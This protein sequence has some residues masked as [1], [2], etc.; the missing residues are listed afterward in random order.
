MYFGVDYY[1]EHWVFPYGGT[2]KNPRRLGARRR[3]DGQSRH[4]RRPHRRIHPGASANPRRANTISPGC[5]ASWTSWRS[6]TSR[7]SS[8]RPP[9]RRP[10]GWPRNIPEIL[11]LDERGLRQTRRHP[12][13]GLLE[14]RRLLGIFQTHRQRHGRGAGRPSA[15]DRLAD[16]QQ[17][18]RASHRIFLQRGTRDGMASLAAGQIQ[19]HRAA[20]RHAGPALLGPDRDLLG[21]GAHADVRA[22]ACTIRRWCWIGAASAATPWCSS[23]RCRRTFCTNVARPSRHRQHARLPPQVRSFRHGRSR[24]FRFHRK[25]RRHQI[26]ILRTG[27]RH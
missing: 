24:G 9:P 19:N 2:A 22:H 5:A 16:R 21:P 4:Q 6:T 26:Q 7:S 10:S 15:I 27:L 12:P 17:H 3:I 25:Q 8:A 11:P 20:Q 23:S 13:R 18:R 14:Q 1:P